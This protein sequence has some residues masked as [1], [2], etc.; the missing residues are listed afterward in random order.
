YAVKVVNTVR[1]TLG[2]IRIDER[3]R[4]LDAHSVPVPGLFAGGNETTGF[5]GGTYPQIDGLTLAF[6]FNS[7]RIAGET[8]AEF[9]SR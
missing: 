1:G 8:A 7:G 4:V 5:Y 3:A 9:L 6:A 2:G